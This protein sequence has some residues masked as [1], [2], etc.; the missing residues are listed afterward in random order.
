[1]RPSYNRFFGFYQGP[2][3]WFQQICLPNLLRLW[4]LSRLWMHI[5]KTGFVEEA[6]TEKTLIQ[7]EVQLWPCSV[8]YFDPDKLFFYILLCKLV[9]TIRYMINSCDKWSTGFHGNDQC[10]SYMI[11][12]L[13][14]QWSTV[15][16]NDQQSFMAM[17]NVYLTWSTVF[18]PM[19]DVD[20]AWTVMNDIVHKAMNNANCIYT[21]T[22]TFLL[23][24]SPTSG[25]RRGGDGC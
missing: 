23:S 2:R 25:E 8:L 15:V 24:S 11:N 5:Y 4:V 12:S 1:M 19:I 22:F 10:L 18:H 17:I 20:H 21:L 13:S 7:Q 16:I 6:Q 9:I 3:A 14:Y